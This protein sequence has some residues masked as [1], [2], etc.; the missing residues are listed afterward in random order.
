MPNYLLPGLT[1]SL[2]LLLYMQSSAGAICI[3]EITIPQIYALQ[4]VRKAVLLSEQG[5]TLLFHGSP[6]AFDHLIHRSLLVH[7]AFI[8]MENAKSSGS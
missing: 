4:T 5:Y 3:L 8:Q 2:I 1:W 7:Q 6:N